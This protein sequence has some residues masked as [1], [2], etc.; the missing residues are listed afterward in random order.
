MY[1][2]IRENRTLMSQ[3]SDSRSLKGSGRLTK[4]KMFYVL[5]MDV[6]T[7]ILAQVIFL[8]LV[9]VAI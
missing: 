2:I 1:I 5:V 8:Y 6:I 4:Y 3:I 9:Q 7:N